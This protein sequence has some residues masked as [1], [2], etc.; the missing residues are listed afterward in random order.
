MAKE[1]PG[2]KQLLAAQDKSI[3][4]P[5]TH[6]MTS[7]VPQ[8]ERYQEPKGRIESLALDDTYFGLHEDEDSQ[9]DALDIL[10]E[11]QQQQQPLRQGLENEHQAV[12]ASP[13]HRLRPP[14][15]EQEKYPMTNCIEAVYETPSFIP[16]QDMIAAALQKTRAS[17]PSHTTK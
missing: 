14:S 8:K 10:W 3:L 6:N 4:D 17:M 1:L 16:T 13:P 11:Q 12:L 2:V 15:E 5:S 9:M 7:L